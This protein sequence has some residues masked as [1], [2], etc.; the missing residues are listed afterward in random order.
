MSDREFDGDVSWRCKQG[1]CEIQFV[2][3]VKGKC[4]N[5]KQWTFLGLPDRD[6]VSCMDWMIHWPGLAWRSRKKETIK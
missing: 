1:G 2:G 3:H 5:C 4:E 6:S